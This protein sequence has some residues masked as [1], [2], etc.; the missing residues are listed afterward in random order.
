MKYIIIL[1]Y[2]II[3]PE[4]EVDTIEIKKYN[5]FYMVI[6]NDNGY[7]PFISLTTYN[8]SGI[9]INDMNFIEQFGHASSCSVSGE[10]NKYDFVNDYLIE[11]ST[12]K[13]DDNCGYYM[14]AGE[15]EEEYL[16][17]LHR[18]DNPFLILAIKT[19]SDIL[20]YYQVNNAGVFTLLE[21][22]SREDLAQEIY[23]LSRLDSFPLKQLRIL[24]NYIFAR[25][26]YAFKSQDLRVYF[27][28][29]EWYTPRF[30][31]VDDQLTD[32]DRQ[33]INYILE[34]EASGR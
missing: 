33:I 11:V 8:Y 5:S 9:E 30:D 15:N 24:R 25:Y 23:D 26:G 7:P 27:S 12:H 16:K 20:N 14:D 19:E 13:L 1:L 28:Q 2:V 17:K 3:Q 31:N 34:L 6:T 21:N 18:L 32:I 4:N 22:R 10:S 29:Y